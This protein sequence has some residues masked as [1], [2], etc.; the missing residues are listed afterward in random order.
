MVVTKESV[1]EHFKNKKTSIGR[2]RFIKKM[3]DDLYAKE[4]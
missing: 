2:D 3:R 1:N 4:W